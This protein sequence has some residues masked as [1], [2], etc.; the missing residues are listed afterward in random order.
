MDNDYF[1][2]DMSEV[3]KSIDRAEVLTMYFPMLRKTL[4]VDGRRNDSDGPLVKVVPMVETPDERVKELRKLRPRFP[5]PDSIT[6]IPWP[7]YVA[8]LERLGVL[9]RLISRFAHA[10]D[11]EQVSQCQAAFAELQKL[12]RQEIRDAIVGENYET[13]WDAETSGAVDDEEADDD[14][15]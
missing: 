6:F 12:E 9:E 3:L 2:V 13:L 4:L 10:G 5:V 7:K 11:E 8:S 15:F 14:E 1:R